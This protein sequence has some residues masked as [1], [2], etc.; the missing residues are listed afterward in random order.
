MPSSWCSPSPTPG[1]AEVVARELAPVVAGKIVLDA[2]N[3][4]K[5]DFSGLVTE[6]GPS[7][8]EHWAEWLPGA[9]VVKAFNTLFAGVQGD[10]LTHGVELDGLFATDDDASREPVAQ[11]LRSNRAAADRR[12]SPGSCQ[13]ARGAGM[14][15]H[16]A[17][18]AA[19]RR[20]EDGV[21]AHWP[22]VG[23]D[24]N[25]DDDDD[26]G[27]EPVGRNVRD[28]LSTPSFPSAGCP[29]PRNGGAQQRDAAGVA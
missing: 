4:I 26:E 20:L 16:P 19:R 11:L 27:V 8:G 1:S 18:V 3:P 23:R 21:R 10:P 14:A 17:P 24:D 9:R 6:G 22:A 15:E 28:D 7:A 2:T 12:R 5:P 13:G 29:R 25:D